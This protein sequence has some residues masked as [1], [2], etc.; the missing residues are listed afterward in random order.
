MYASL[1]ALRSLFILLL[2]CLLGQ[3]SIYGSRML[4]DNMLT[5]I[6]RSPMSFFDTT[7][8]GRILNRF[9][10]VYRYFD[11][12]YSIMFVIVCFQD[13][14]TI[15]EEIPIA[16]NVFLTQFFYILS[17]IL[18]IAIASPWFMVALVPLAIFY[19]FIQV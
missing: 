5:A 2:F 9:S 1:G 3:A 17:T 15:D 8:L 10:M 6:F 14:Y 16:V 13:M 18:V 4:H 12:K 19:G 7:P 11:T